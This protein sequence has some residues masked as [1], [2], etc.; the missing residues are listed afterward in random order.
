MT[1]TCFCTNPI[2]NGTATHYIVTLTTK[3]EDDATVLVSHGTDEPDGE[4]VA[5]E[6]SHVRSL[7]PLPENLDALLN[8]RYGTFVY[9]STAARWRQ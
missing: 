6:W 9:D 3:Y 1:I 7:L 2:L 5:A 8:Q 4:L